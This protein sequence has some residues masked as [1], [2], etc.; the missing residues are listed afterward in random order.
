[1]PSSLDAPALN[2]DRENHATIVHRRLR[3]GFGGQGS[4]NCTEV[5][6]PVT[7]WTTVV[8]LGANRHRW[9]ENRADY[10]DASIPMRS[11]TWAGPGTFSNEK[12]WYDV[13]T[14]R[15]AIGLSRDGR[16]LTLFTVDV[17]GG[18]EGMRGGR[19]RRC[20]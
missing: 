4:D 13:A 11:C 19:G 15:T 6:E 20:C 1:M 8:G 3:R 7:L 12:S 5:A 10:K 16:T 17:R 14:A 2:I 18:S 9:R